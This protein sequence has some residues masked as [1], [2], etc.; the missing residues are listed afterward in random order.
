MSNVALGP[1]LGT[2]GKPLLDDE[3][4][5]SEGMTLVDGDTTQGT[6]FVSFER[7]HRIVAL[8]LHR[9]QIRTADRN[10]ALAGRRRSA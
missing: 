2:D 6:A 7:K 5:D 4:R 9:R 1:L 8:S 10:R 3:D